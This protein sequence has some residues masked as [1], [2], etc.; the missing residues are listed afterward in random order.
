MREVLIRKAKE[1][2]SELKW[3][4]NI[5]ENETGT[6]NKPLKPSENESRPI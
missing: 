1:L 5:S 6:I 2:E 3:A 4:S